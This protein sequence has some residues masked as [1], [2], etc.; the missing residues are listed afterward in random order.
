[1]LAAKQLLLTRFF[2]LEIGGFLEFS[3][4]LLGNINLYSLGQTVKEGGAIVID[5][6]L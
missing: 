2:L 3:C 1:M 6:F 4:L 5:I